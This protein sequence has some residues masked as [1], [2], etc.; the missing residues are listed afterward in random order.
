MVFAMPDE[1]LVFINTLFQEG[2]LG[3]PGRDF[4]SS[5]FPLH[6]VY[7]SARLPKQQL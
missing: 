4:P 7:C 5:E 2:F 3:S 6:L 1:F